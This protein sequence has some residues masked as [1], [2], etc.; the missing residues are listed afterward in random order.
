MFSMF[1]GVLLLGIGFALGVA[2]I[3]IWMAKAMGEDP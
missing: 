3:A 1:V 2:A